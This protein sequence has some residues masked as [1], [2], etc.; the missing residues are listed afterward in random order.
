MKKQH[1]PLASRMHRGFEGDNRRGKRKVLVIFFSLISLGL[2]GATLATNVSI[3]GNRG[4]TLEFGQGSVL[5]LACDTS[6][7]TAVGEVWAPSAAPTPLF[8]ANSLTLT[9]VDL[10]NAMPTPSATPAGNDG[11]AGQTIVVQALSSTGGVLAGPFPIPI[12]S[13][14]VATPYT[15]NGTGFVASVSPGPSN[16][17]NSQIVIT[18]FSPSPTASAI[19]RV[20]IETK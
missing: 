19:D 10:R 8:V 16:G 18:G 13:A 1:T 4:N 17:A 6:I 15:I 12:P 5:S 9:D 7:N 11:C 2:F 14:T 20:A 3:N